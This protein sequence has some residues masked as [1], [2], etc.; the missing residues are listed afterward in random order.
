MGLFTEGD[1]NPKTAKSIL[2]NYLTLILHLAP[3]KLSGFEVCASRSAGCTIACLNT[4]GRGKMT[5][6][7]VARIKRTK[8]FFE[9]RNDFKRDITKELTSFVRKCDKHQLQPAVRMNGTSDI[10]WE[11]VWPELFQLFPQITF[12]DYTKHLKRA[13][14][15]W[16]LPANYHLT[17]SRAEDND[18]NC[19]R[20]LNEGRLNVA[21]VFLTKKF[22]DSWFDVP[23]YSADD[24]D[25]RFLDPTLNKFK[26]GGMVGC[27]YAKGK[28]KKDETGFVIKLNAA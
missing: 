2:L 1:A 16:A 20:V 8:Y 28:A 25:L 4:A 18:A 27:L 26:T 19:I 17:F 14:N 6:V 11:N 24:T 3:A 23:T 15:N 13:I 7:Q 9:H 10:V 21:A 12:Y 5:A 22:P